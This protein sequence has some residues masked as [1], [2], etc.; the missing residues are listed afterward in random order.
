MH[1]KP[2]SKT[3]KIWCQNLKKDMDRTD[4]KNCPYYR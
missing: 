1:A 2:S 4:G 3:G